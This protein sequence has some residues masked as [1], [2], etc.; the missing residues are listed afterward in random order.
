MVQLRVGIHRAE[1]GPQVAPRGCRAR[2]P[3]REARSVQP[4]PAD[5]RSRA[6]TTEEAL[7]HG[8]TRRML[9]G[10]RFVSLH[11]GRGIWA[12]ADEPRDLKFLLRADRLILPRDATVSHV[13][14]LHLHGVDIGESS[15][16]HWSTNQPVQRRSESIVLHRRQAPLSPGRIDGIPVLPASRCLVD[17]AISLS[18]RDIVRAA[19]A[20]IEAGSMTV[21]S[22]TTYVWSRRLHGVR[23]SRTNAGRAREQVKSFR[24]TDLRLLLAVAGLPEAEV[25]SDIF[26]DRGTHLGCGDLV[27]RRWR[28]VIEYDGWYHERSADQRRKD[29]IRREGLEADGW[30]VI[31]VLSGQL[32][33]PAGLVGRVWRA[34]VSRG[35]AGPPPRLLP[36]EYEEL[37]RNPKA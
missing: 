19:D 32:D 17:A 33:H 11:P 23:R 24:E 16:R 6:F 22:F 12:V 5:L 4:I 25:N 35:Y 21:E 3:W 31:V 34:L 27:L 15:I 26:D 18:H 13:T 28:I 9:D 1:L 29:V 14:G 8:V 30:L 36:W 7:T 10:R 37:H 2:P 20:L